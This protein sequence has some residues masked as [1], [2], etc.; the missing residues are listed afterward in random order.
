MPKPVAVDSRGHDHPSLKDL[1]RFERAGS[2]YTEA[3]W[4]NTDNALGYLAGAL[5]TV[6]YVFAAGNHRLFGV[7]MF[8]TAAAIAASG[9]TGQFAPLLGLRFVSGAAGAMAFICGGVLASGAFPGRPK[10]A[11]TAIAIYFAGGRV[12]ILL[13]GAGIPW[14][15]Q[16]GGNR[17]WPAA[18]LALGGAS[19]N[20]HRP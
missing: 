11:S 9:L 7:G 3:G 14:L 1:I 18:W 20:N 16:A 10:L 6:R 13:S 17:A 15:L 8:V 5:F 19:A 2:S 12:G 4:L